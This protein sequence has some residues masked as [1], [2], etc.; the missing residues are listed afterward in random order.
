MPTITQAPPETSEPL[1]P[2]DA[3]KAIKRSSIKRDRFFPYALSAPAAFLELLIHIVPMLL[4][5]WIAFLSLTQFSIANWVKAPFVGLQNFITA[6]D[7][8][9]PIGS[10]FFDA[11]G[12]TFLFTVLVV[13]IAWSLGIFAA[14]LLASKFRGNG[15]FRTL[16]LVPYALPSYVTTIA[17]AFMFNQRDGMVNRF[18]VEDLG[19]LDEGPFWLLGGNSFFVMVVVA[20]WQFWPFA[21]LMLLAAVQSIPNEVYEAASLDGAS[22]WKQFTS[23]TLPMI[24]HA[25]VVLL[26]ML[27]LWV[28]NQFDIPYL[29]FGPVSPE[30]ATLISPLIYQQSFNN[31][32]F[33][34]GGALSVVLLIALLI[35]SAFYIRLVMPKEKSIDD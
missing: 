22:L 6:L 20:V 5:V 32:N 16:F 11:L 23:I 35:V 29:L 10:Q 12:R 21:F 14:V 19:I 1:K 7:P 31:W 3:S 33:G 15:F 30:E 9:G 25:N 17:W 8:N 2:R 24:K 34:V 27:G 4:G 26:L 13:A 28:F 18:L